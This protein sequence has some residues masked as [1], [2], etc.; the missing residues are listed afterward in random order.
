MTT[1]VAAPGDL[2]IGVSDGVSVRFAGIN[3]EARQPPMASPDGD[4]CIQIMLE[5][6]NDLEVRRRNQQHA[7]DEAAWVERRRELGTQNAGRYP[8]LPGDAVLQRVRARVTDDLGTSYHWIGG[9]TSGTGSEWDSSWF[10]FPAP[11][12]TASLLTLTFTLDDEPTGKECVIRLR[13][14]QAP[15]TL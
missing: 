2:I 6:V 1:I 4:S 13:D 5:G 10:Y 11:P 12:R 8:P 9:H 15:G 14:G 3:V 7:R